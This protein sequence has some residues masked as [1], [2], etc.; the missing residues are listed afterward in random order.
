[1]KML[2]YVVMVDNDVKMS[3]VIVDSERAF[4]RELNDKYGKDNVLK[5]IDITQ[6]V[7]FKHSIPD[8][9]IDDITS[10]LSKHEDYGQDTA[11]FIKAVLKKALKD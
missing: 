5:V 4:V 8:L 7:V 9:L 10:F 3:T 1:M 2:K 11:D 6:D